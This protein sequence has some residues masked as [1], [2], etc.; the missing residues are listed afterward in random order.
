MS[1][2]LRCRCDRTTG[3]WRIPT[4]AGL[5]RLAHELD[6]RR[7]R[8][9]ADPDW[10]PAPRRRSFGARRG[11]RVAGTR[12]LAK[13][14]S[15]STTTASG[16]QLQAAHAN[17][18]ASGA[19]IEQAARVYEIADLRF[20]RRTLDAAG[21][22]GRAALARSGSGDACPRGARPAGTAGAV[23]AAAELPLGGLSI[24]AS[25]G[26]VATAN[27]QSAGAA[28][29]TTGGQAAATTAAGAAGRPLR[30]DSSHARQV[31]E[32]GGKDWPQVWA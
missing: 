12:E 2:G 15:R 13:E 29:Q 8:L 32:S 27:T 22:L 9:D 31:D 10:R 14:L 25:G 5:Q 17:W 28:T 23:C 1:A 3:S 18:Q 20:P 30:E 19:T 26:G 11:R 7:R 4:R 6:G 21:A 16:L 24:S